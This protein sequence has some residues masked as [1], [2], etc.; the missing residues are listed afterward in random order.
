MRDTQQALVY[1][2]ETK[3]MQST[4]DALVDLQRLFE[5]DAERAAE[6]RREKG[7]AVPDS[8]E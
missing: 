2:D 5:A 1:D 8:P 3:L 6:R 7:P 4:R